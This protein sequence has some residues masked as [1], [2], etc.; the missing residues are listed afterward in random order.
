[1]NA[2]SIAMQGAIENVTGA[3][4][5]ALASQ[6]V[7]GASGYGTSALAVSGTTTLNQSGG[8]ASGATSM[9]VTNAS[10]AGIAV[11]S[12]IAVGVSSAAGAIGATY[13]EIQWVTGV[14]GNTVTFGP[15][16]AASA[17]TWA[18]GTYIAVLPAV[19]SDCA[20]AQS[21]TG[22]DLGTSVVASTAG[23]ATWTGPVQANVYIAALRTGFQY[24]YLGLASS[25]LALASA[26]P[27]G[28]G[29]TQLAQIY[30]GNP[31][32]SGWS[33]YPTIPFGGSAV[34]TLEAATA[35]FATT[36]SSA[37]SAGAASLAI[38]P[39][40]ITWAGTTLQGYEV[41]VGDQTEPAELVFAYFNIA[42]SVNLTMNTQFAHASGAQYQ[43]PTSSGLSNWTFFPIYHVGN[44][45]QTVTFSNMTMTIDPR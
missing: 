37:V 28:P 23:T 24:D 32:G 5:V 14:S 33:A 21:P 35:W 34:V 1:M 8:L 6:S 31:S 20:T 29:I 22:V 41:M 27:P 11:G 3:Q 30:P 10:A 4:T 25:V 26:P 2:Q 13:P 40:S 43:S 16:I 45:A 19:T 44:V 36:I 42:N 15:G 39:A 7:T 18:N 12:V 17:G 38:T 9:I